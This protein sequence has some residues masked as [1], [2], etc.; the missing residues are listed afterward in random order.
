VLDVDAAARE[1]LRRRCL[2]AAHE[3]WNWET[4]SARL[5]E[6]YEELRALRAG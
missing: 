3:R 2:K 1:D 4:E 6:L 5:V